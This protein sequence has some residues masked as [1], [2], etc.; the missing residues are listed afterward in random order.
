MSIAGPTTEWAVELIEAIRPNETIS[1]FLARMQREDEDLQA[2][3]QA[4]WL[5]VLEKLG[6]DEAATV[7]EA[8]KRQSFVWD[9]SMGMTQGFNTGVADADKTLEV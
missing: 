4:P 7:I 2:H 9:V 3:V 6:E 8:S 1:S 5:Q